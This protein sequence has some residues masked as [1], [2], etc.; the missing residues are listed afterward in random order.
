M[1][2]YGVPINKLFPVEIDTWE[3]VDGRLILQYNQDH[4]VQYARH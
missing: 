1:S 2:A 4:S 3:I